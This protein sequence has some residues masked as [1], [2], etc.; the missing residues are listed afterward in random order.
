[1]RVS[2]PETKLM[3]LNRGTF[4]RILGSIKQYLKEDYAN[5]KGNVAGSSPQK[6][7]GDVDGSFMSDQDGLNSNGNNS[8]LSQQNLYGIQE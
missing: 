4:T 8:F 1:M 7:V 2:K 3:S 6:E 5:D